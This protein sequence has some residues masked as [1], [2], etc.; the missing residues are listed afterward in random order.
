MAD[1]IGN[2]DPTVA[3]TIDGSFGNDLI[4]G[5]LGDDTIFGGYGEDEIWGDRNSASEPMGGADILYGG[6]NNDKLYGE[7]GDDQLHGDA[8]NDYLVGGLGQDSMFGGSGN[9]ALTVGTMSE[10]FGDKVDGGSGIDMLFA[11]YSARETRLIF[12]A[13]DP[14]ATYK[15]YGGYR[16]TNVEMYQIT[17]T[18]FG[19]EMSGWRHD[20]YFIAGAG[21]DILKG[22]EGQD[23]LYGGDGEDVLHGGAGH[24]RMYGDNYVGSYADKLYG[25][26]GN[27]SMYGRGGDD[28]LVGDAGQDTLYGEDG[29]DRMNGGDGDD[30]LIGEA[31]ADVLVGGTGNDVLAAHQYSWMSESVPESDFDT[32]DAGAGNDKVTLG[33]GDSAKGGAGIDT[34]RLLFRHSDVGITYVLGAASTTL[35]NNTVLEGFE[36]IE[37][38]GGSG[39]DRVTGG[40]LVDNLNGYGGNDILK[41]EGG[42]D[43][44]DGGLGDDV[45]QG[46]AGADWLGDSGAGDDKFFGGAD[47]DIIYVESGADRA[48][49]EAG[50]D[51]F[52]VGSDD[53]AADS[54]N[55]GEGHDY[56][57]LG[58][59]SMA[60]YLDLA[61]QTKNDGGIKNDMFYSVEQFQGS[62]HSDVMLG[63]GFANHLM[64]GN[65][66]D[67]LDGRGGDDRLDG[68]DGSDAM[69]GG[70]GA[71]TFVLEEAHDYYNSQWAAD[72]IA[73]FTRGTDKLEVD[74]YKFG[75][76][77][78]PDNG[79]EQNLAALPPFELRLELGTELASTGEGPMFFFNTADHRLWFDADGAG[80][81]S[82]LLLIATLDGVNTLSLDDF[83]FVADEGYSPSLAE[84][85]ASAPA[86]I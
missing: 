53:G 28:Y 23:D 65:S 43:Y 55:G 73:D 33:V 14:L 74:L 32:I 85:S 37:F 4:K 77:E 16:I 46:G 25:G 51:E 38:G 27:D 60:I 78:E 84:V 45:L 2:D 8:G 40:A 69:A 36:Q 3:E 1:I 83:V 64:G 10:M 86:I 52:R 50:D 22:Y 48:N 6:F 56:A 81:E 76:V 57:H 5:M 61:D 34:I 41:L 7:V 15:A 17:G 21:N 70:A 35:V 9:D 31:G 29:A 20:D 42:D 49:G 66:D 30:S 26:V 75:I 67:V 44:A 59:G 62:Y 79:N 11:D 19:D 71:D 63:N 24:D 82:S 80:S 72:T 54:I 47:N 12:T 13:L 58:Y 68:G 39:D 18:A